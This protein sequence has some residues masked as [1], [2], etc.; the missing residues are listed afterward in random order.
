[1]VEHLNQSLAHLD[2]FDPLFC[3]TDNDLAGVFHSERNKQC[4]SCV[5]LF[6]KVGWTRQ[7][8]KRNPHMHTPAPGIVFVVPVAMIAK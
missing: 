8:R 2:G 7:G 3:G 4:A 5:V 1:M 6:D